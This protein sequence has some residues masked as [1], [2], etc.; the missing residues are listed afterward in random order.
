[1]LAR[2]VVEFAWSLPLEYKVRD[3]QGKWLLRQVLA[4]HVPEALFERPKMGFGVPIDS[5]LRGPL[6]DWA[7]D[8]LDEGRLEREGLLAAGPIRRAWREHLSG[9]RN[10]QYH[11]WG[12]LMFQSWLRAQSS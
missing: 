9:E 4:R 7:E 11:L 1:M 3:G 10:W 2:D 12:V 8:L 5:W 6:R